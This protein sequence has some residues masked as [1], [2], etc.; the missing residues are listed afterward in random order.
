ML[1]FRAVWLPLFCCALTAGCGGLTTF[2]GP[3]AQCEI[4]DLAVVLERPSE[5]HGKQFCGL[6]YANFQSGMY[7]FYPH[8]LAAA[9]DP[10]DRALVLSGTG[11]ATEKHLKKL[12]TNDV[13]FVAGIIDASKSCV[14]GDPDSGREICA[15]ISHPVFIDNPK[16]SPAE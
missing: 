15:P 7:A 9:D 4:N 3:D 13:A 12:N 5:F 10:Y 8:A 14:T 11:T 1:T 6:A 2:S 16:V